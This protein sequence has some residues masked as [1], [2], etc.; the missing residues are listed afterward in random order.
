MAITKIDSNRFNDVIYDNSEACVVAFT[1]KDCR[2]CKEVVPK[3]EEVAGSYD[4]K[5][6][7]YNVDMEEEKS[8]FKKLSLKG[9]PQLLFFK[10]GELYGKLAGDVEEEDIEEKID[11]MI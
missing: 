5:L 7:F 1:R 2:V 4:G 10:D 3:L 8:L 9:V 6:T 11:D